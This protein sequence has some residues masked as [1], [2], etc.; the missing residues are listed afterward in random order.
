MSG[1][2][3]KKARKSG[4]CA[5]KL[6][7]TVITAVFKKANMFFQKNVIYFLVLNMLAYYNTSVIV[8]P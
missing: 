8:D 4:D 3:V 5:I 2:A 6:Y 7:G 1:E